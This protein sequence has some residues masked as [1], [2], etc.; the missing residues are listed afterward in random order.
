M[1]T[2]LLIDGNALI[3]RAFHA[4]PEFKTKTGVQTNALYGFITMLSKAIEMTSPVYVAVCFDTP[5]PTFRKKMFAQYQIQ[6]PVIKEE[7][8]T[9][10]PFIKEFLK[11]ATI[12]Y[13]EKEGYEA[14]D[15]IGTI[16][17][18]VKTENTKTF[19]F[20]GDKDILQLVDDTTFVITP[21]KGLSEIKLYDINQVKGTFHVSPAQIADIKALMGDAAD[22][23]KGGYGIGPKTAS[24]LIGQFGNIDALYTHLQE[25]KNQRVRETLKKDKE[26]ILL[27][28]ELARIVQNVKF[29]FSLEDCR[30]KQYNEDVK[31]FFLRFEFYSLVKRFFAKDQKTTI[32]KNTQKQKEQLG[33]F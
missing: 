6:R 28:K 19:I 12:S 20:T 1:K 32:S 3:H 13:F 4:L 17:K 22:N 8:R 29:P 33:L 14:D 15:L 11:A 21:K 18:K 10:F 30:F 23:Y 7:M 25:V 31:D 5:T 24:S 27:S 9:Q 16:A 26:H 2:L